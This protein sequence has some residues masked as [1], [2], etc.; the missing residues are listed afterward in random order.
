MINEP[1]Y[2]DSI[3]SFC[4]KQANEQEQQHKYFL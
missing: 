1:D 3:L 2:D 4:I